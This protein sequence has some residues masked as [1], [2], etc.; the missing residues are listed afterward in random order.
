MKS[1]VELNR[2]LNILLCQVDIEE[3]SCK[4]KAKFEFQLRN[5]LGE[6]QVL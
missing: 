1:A 6:Q 3:S 5:D 2:L 4:G